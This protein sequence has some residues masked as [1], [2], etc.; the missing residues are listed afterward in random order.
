MPSCALYM[1]PYPPFK[2]ATLSIYDIT[3]TIYGMSSTLY[4]ITLTACVTSHNA[5]ISDIT[6][7][8]FMRYPLY[9]GSHTVL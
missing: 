7:S 5:C 9:M 2:R 4:D 3:C 1:T 6:H 8:M